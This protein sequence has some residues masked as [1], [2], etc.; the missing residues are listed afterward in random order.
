MRGSGW[1]A[2]AAA[3]GVSLALSAA[4]VGPHVYWQDSGFYLAAIHDLAVLY[5]HGFVL[6]EL[7]CKAWT[8]ALFFVDFTL[9]VHLFSSLCSALAAGALALAARDL[10]RARS[11]LLRTAAE[12]SGGVSDAAG[13]VAGS[14]AACGYTFWMSGIYAKGYS[15]LYLVLAVLLW[16]MIRAAETRRARDFTIVAALIGLAWQAHPS[17]TGAGAAL[18]A[19]V[20]VHRR[21]LGWRGLAWRA[22]LAAALALGPLLLLPLLASGGSPMD[23]GEPTTVSELLRYAAGSRFTGKEGAFDSGGTRWATAGILA[24]EDFLGVGLLL[25]G[26]GAIRLARANR[27]LLAGIVLWWGPYVA[28]TTM[29]G[30]EGQQDH[31]YTA[32]GLPL[33]L[34]IGVGIAALARRAGRGG[35]WLAAGTGLAGLA[36]A[37]LANGPDLNLRSYDL[38]DRFGRIHLE[39]LAPDAVFISTSDDTS[40]TMHYLQRVRG[41]RPDVVIVRRGHLDAGGGEAGGWYDRRL[42]LRDPRLRLPDYAGTR[43]TFPA[44]SRAAVVTAAYLNANA[45]EARAVYVEEPPP[46]GML[47]PGLV[48]VPAGPVWRAARRGA[49][50]LEDWPL[51][52]EPEEVRGRFRRARGQAVERGGMKTSYRA[53]PYERRLF[54]ALLRARLLRAEWHFARRELSRAAELYAAILRADPETG[55]LEEVV[56]P[57]AVSLLATGNATAAE[58]LLLRTLEIARHPPTRAGA[59]LHLGDLARARGQAERASAAY[60]AGLAVPGID[61]RVRKELA[62]RLA[63]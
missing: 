61:E 48:L 22:G 35:L 38:A 13:A 60:R 41:V 15:F 24:W 47:R 33:T 2:P 5:P 8:L 27:A 3:T 58:P 6:Y 37:V 52:L 56:Y 29:F 7:L 12:E 63:P 26:I 46:E 42:V 54:V 62:A 11:P 45:G 53:E 39:P 55:G 21:V 23:F 10:V 16:R 1:A 28:M 14:L 4:T 40:S 51:G 19:F 30:I 57:L 32:A 17:A 31:W 9:A 36:W 43:R 18:L 25:T 44:A 20:V 49:E 50:R 34:L 59:F